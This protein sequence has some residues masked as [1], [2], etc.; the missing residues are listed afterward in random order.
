MGAIEAI[1]RAVV[2][3]LKNTF[4]DSYPDPAL[5][6]LSVQMEYPFEVEHYPGIWVRFSFTRLVRAGVGHMIIKG[7]ERPY[8]EWRFEGSATVQIFGLT[9]MERDRISGAFINM[10]AFG[11]LEASTAT[12]RERLNDSPYINISLNLDEVKSGGQGESVGAPW[13]QDL[14][15]YEDSYSFQM[16]GDFKSSYTD[17]TVPVILEKILVTPVAHMTQEELNAA[18]NLPPDDGNGT[19]V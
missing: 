3:A 5:R 11:E 12:F 15:I 7:I 4:T 13:Q 1:K 10:Y 8:I 18:P 14:L 16:I 17:T 2:E 6:G 9:S 19:W